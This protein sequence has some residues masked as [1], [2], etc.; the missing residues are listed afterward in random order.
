MSKV[1]DQW[2]WQPPARFHR[3]TTVE[4]HTGGRNEL[5]LD[6]EDALGRGF[7]FR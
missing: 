5:Y 1:F 2:H 7:N 3:I 6:P 4:M